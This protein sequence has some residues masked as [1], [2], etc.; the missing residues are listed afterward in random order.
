MAQTNCLLQL[1][2]ASH[3]PVPFTYLTRSFL[4]LDIDVTGLD[5]N[6]CDVTEGEALSSLQ[7]KVFWG[8]H[9]CHNETTQAREIPRTQF[10][11]VREL[12]PP[13][14]VGVHH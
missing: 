9:K 13:H 12:E 5:V 3:P 8:T 10:T 4:S 14:A 11:H 2:H 1:L 7:I 6:Q